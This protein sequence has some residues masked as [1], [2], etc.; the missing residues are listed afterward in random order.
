M[1][2]TLFFISVFL[3][4]SLIL[5]SCDSDS[6]SDSNSSTSESKSEFIV[7]FD[8]NITAKKG[9]ASSESIPSGST[10]EENET[11]SFTCNSEGEIYQWTIGSTNNTQKDNYISFNAEKKYAVKNGN[12]YT[13]TVKCTQRAA[14]TAKLT[15]D[16]SIVSCVYLDRKLSSGETVKEGNEVSFYNINKGIF[17]DECLFNGKSKGTTLLGNSIRLIEISE[18]EFKGGTIEATFKTHKSK[19]AKLAYNKSEM[20]IKITEPYY[21]SEK[22]SVPSRKEK[23]YEDGTDIDIYEGDTVIFYDLAG[24]R[25]TAAT[26]NGTKLGTGTNGGNIKLNNAKDDV[27]FYSSAG[28][29]FVDI[30]SINGKFTVSK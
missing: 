26:V 28:T 20:K 5:T 4:A 23:S 9:F 11:L 18:D 17:L 13:I 29:G 21:D 22:Q 3:S 7:N 1:K 27:V 14:Y 30:A 6:D 10:V 19:T 24:G 2:K 8:S 12:K 16:E 15:F 25:L